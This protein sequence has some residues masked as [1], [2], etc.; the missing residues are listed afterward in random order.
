MHIKGHSVDGGNDRAD[1][2]VQWGEAD[3]SYIRI[4]EGGG[5]EGPG[6]AVVVTEPP[7]GV[8]I[9]PEEER[10]QE[11]ASNADEDDWGMFGSPMA[12]VLEGGV[13]DVAEGPSDSGWRDA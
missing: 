10:E 9:K 11:Y 13:E 12:G 6:N 5:A 4:V 7:P 8:N 1:L 2:L 3:G